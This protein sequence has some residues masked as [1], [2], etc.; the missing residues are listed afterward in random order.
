MWEHDERLSFKDFLRY[1]NNEDVVPTV[2]AMKKRVESYQ[3]T[4]IGMVNFG[5]TLPNLDNI[6]PYSSISEKIDPF[7]EN[8]RIFFQ[9]FE[10]IWLQDHQ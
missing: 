2:E 7:T 10:K 3:N 4:G 8:N 9:K 1:F 5:C 6:C